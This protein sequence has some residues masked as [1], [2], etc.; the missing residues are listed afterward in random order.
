MLSFQGRK[1]G[2]LALK[3]IEP[4]NAF[5]DLQVVSCVFV[6]QDSIKYKALPLE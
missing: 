5:V 6:L 3:T 1:R 2:C 4:S